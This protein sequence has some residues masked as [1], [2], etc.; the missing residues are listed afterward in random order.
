M[1]CQRTC[2]RA[3]KSR[4]FYFN[5]ARGGVV[6][7]GSFGTQISRCEAARPQFELPTD[8][9]PYANK[10]RIRILW[11][12]HLCPNGNVS[13]HEQ[14]TPPAENLFLVVEKEGLRGIQGVE[15]QLR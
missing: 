3:Q 4:G 1:S 2:V 6:F 7:A 14:S 10:K 9:R 5:R 15:W 12:E 13:L 8:N 11:A